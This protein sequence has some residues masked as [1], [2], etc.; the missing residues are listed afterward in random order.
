VFAETLGISKEQLY[1]MSKDE[2]KALFEK[3][4][5]YQSTAAD[6]DYLKKVELQGQV[7]K[8]VDHSISVTINL[9]EDTAQETV[10]ALY[11]KA[12]ESGC[13]GMTVYREG[14]RSGVLVDANEKDKKKPKHN[15]DTH[16]LKRPKEL[17]AEIVRFKNDN[18]DWI[19][20]IGTK[21][22]R[23]Y[24]IFT[25]KAEDD[26][27]PLSKT[28]TEGFIIKNRME[29]GRKQY[30]FMYYDADGY[31]VIMRGLSRCFN[32]E[33]WNYAKMISAL[34]RHDI[35]V[36][37]VVNIIEG[38]NFREETINSWKN[39]VIRALKKFIADGTKAKKQKC[40]NCGET[41]TME[42]KEG[43]LT[44]VACSYSKCG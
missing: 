30:D 28:L 7:Q 14:S 16:N 3:S 29:D 32:P 13:K 37:N 18:E 42:F 17:T 19:A 8:W 25:G 27:F 11:L 21:E 22:G 5:Y 2:V 4:P 38:L 1:K 12:W 34:L 6:T 26:R 9:P 24:E 43:C 36:E 33:F 35:P 41:D 40:P 44:C 10:S 39:G 31:E 20:F 23:P 15:L